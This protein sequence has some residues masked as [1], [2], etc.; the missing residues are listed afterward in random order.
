[1]KLC[2]YGTYVTFAGL[3]SFVDLIVTFRFDKVTLEQLIN[4]DIFLIKAQIQGP[5]LLWLYQR[6]ILLGVLPFY[7]PTQYT[8][9]RQQQMIV[10]Y[11]KF[12]I[13]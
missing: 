3:L 7:K 4:L 13:G 9:L 1:M 2:L 6:T 8:S 5:S 11:H 10:R 12:E